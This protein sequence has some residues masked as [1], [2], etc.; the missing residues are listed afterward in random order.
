MVCVAHL[1]SFFAFAALALAYFPH[2]W[3]VTVS[4]PDDYE[5]IQAA[6]I[7]IED[8]PDP[9]FDNVIEVARGVY[10]ETLTMTGGDAITIVG[11]EAAA[12]FLEA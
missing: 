2:C 12:T 8:D 5:T 3:A 11:E 10:R 7:A 1:R 4:V 9:D 6:I